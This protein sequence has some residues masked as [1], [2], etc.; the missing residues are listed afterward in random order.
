MW[1]G[2]N[3]S[4][5]FA[6]IADVY[7]KVG[8]LRKYSAAREKKRPPRSAE[9]VFYKPESCRRVD[10]L[11]ILQG[12]HLFAAYFQIALEAGDTR[13]ERLALILEIDDLV[14]L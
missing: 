12:F 3:G 7:Q 11:L 14:L 9:A 5:N 6:A 8:R 10:G 13:R 1:L 2:M 4:G